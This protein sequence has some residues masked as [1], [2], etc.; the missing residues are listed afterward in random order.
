MRELLQLVFDKFGALL[1]SLLQSQPQALV[2]PPQ[3][4]R[5]ARNFGRF[6]NGR[7]AVPCPHQAQHHVLLELAE[8]LRSLPR[9]IPGQF[10]WLD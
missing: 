5:Q 7:Q 8:S 1:I 4:V 9:E 10:K 2:K 3:A 6:R